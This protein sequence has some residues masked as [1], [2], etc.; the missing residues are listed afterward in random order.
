MNQSHHVTDYEILSE[1]DPKALERKIKVAIHEG[2]QPF[3][4]PCVSPRGDGFAA[5]YAQ[6][7]V[8]YADSFG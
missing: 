7:L 4:S 5:V 6:A 3:G 1:S 2:W 8:K